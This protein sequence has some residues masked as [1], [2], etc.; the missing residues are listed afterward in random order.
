VRAAALT[1]GRAAELVADPA[2]ETSWHVLAKAA[3]MARV[4]LWD[5]APERPWRPDEAAAVPPAVLTLRP[6]IISA[7][8]TLGPERHVVS[9]MGVSGHYGLPVEGFARAVGA[10]V[11][12]LFWEP[13][14]QTLTEFACRLS[15]AH[16]GALHFLAGT[17]EADGAK[18]RRDAERALRTLKIDRLA[19]FLLFWVQSWQRITPD[20]REALV[21]L[22]AEGK[23]ATVGLS[24]HSRPLAVE[25]MT[26]GWDPLMVR[27]SAAHR[28]AEEHVFPEA[29]ERGT[30]IITFNNTCYGRLLQ[31][32]GDEPPPG[33]ADC[34]RYTLAQPAVTA[35]WSAPAT[36]EQLEENLRALSDPDLPD[37]RRQRLRAHGDWVYQEDATFRVLVRSR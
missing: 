21:R 23:V 33:A 31:P 25:A 32:H 22:K 11:N 17:F 16:R 35:C 18:V 27:H 19:I 37:D 4:P 29:L 14:Y 28:G 13:N 7:R 2:R 6:T 8:R 26:A 15:V 5:L 36:L 12:L 1:P 3:R 10:G 34:Y 24:T 30:G 9:P 20:V